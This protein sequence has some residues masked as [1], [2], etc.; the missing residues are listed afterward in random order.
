MR[1][2]A[3]NDRLVTA[4]CTTQLIFDLFEDD[5]YHKVDVEVEV[6]ARADDKRTATSYVW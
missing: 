1:R 3:T 5:D 6:E 4:L 2:F